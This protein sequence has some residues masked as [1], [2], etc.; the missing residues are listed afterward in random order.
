VV[1]DREAR[2]AVGVAAPGVRRSGVRT[3]RWAALI[4]C[5]RAAAQHTSARR[6]LGQELFYGFLR[7]RL[8]LGLF[9]EFDERGVRRQRGDLS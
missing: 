5:G 6:V 8:V 1:P 7:R 2:R 3:A 9:P 4:K